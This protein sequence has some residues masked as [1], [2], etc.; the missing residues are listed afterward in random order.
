M[1]G[2][3]ESYREY[4]ERNRCRRAEEERVVAEG[5]TSSGK[6]RHVGK[7]RGKELVAELEVWVTASLKLN[8]SSSSQLVEA[9]GGSALISL[10]LAIQLKP[11]VQQKEGKSAGADWS[12]FSLF[13]VA[14]RDKR[15]HLDLKQIKECYTKSGVSLS[16]SLCCFW[17]Q[18]KGN[19]NHEPA[20]IFYRWS[21][22]QIN[23]RC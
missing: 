5:M 17:E 6:K 10:S 3:T 19:Q 2:T 21:W 22:W 4:G 8:L 9:V 12:L 13:A 11:Y 14:A 1:R 15:I 20:R 16:V 18:E 23:R 7:V